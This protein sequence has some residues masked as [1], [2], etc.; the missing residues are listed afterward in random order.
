MVTPADQGVGPLTG[1]PVPEVAPLETQPVPETL[2]ETPPVAEATPSP[3]PPPSPPAPDTGLRQALDILRQRL[4]QERA[5]LSQREA[6]A[7]EREAWAVAQNAQSALAKELEEQEGLTPERAA[8]LAQ[9]QIG[10][11]WQAYQSQQQAQTATDE[12]HAKVQVAEIMSGQYAIPVSEL[13]RYDSPEAMQA[14][15]ERMKAQNAQATRIAQLEAQVAK[16]TKGAVPAQPFSQGIVGG[17][18]STAT[19]DNIDA[20][21]LKD[22]AR[23]ADVYRKFLATRNI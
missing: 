9:R 2:P 8:A 4:S 21:Y 1:A 3:T 7:R 11:I 15:G 22:E 23:Y 16:L 19:P 13:L 14:A 17:D 6:V 18:G 12:L 20:L 10:M 5:Q